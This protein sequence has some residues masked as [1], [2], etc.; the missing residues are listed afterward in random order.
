[1]WGMKSSVVTPFEDT[2]QPRSSRRKGSPIARES[3]PV[4]EINVTDSLGEKVET[5][6]PDNPPPPAAMVKK[7]KKDWSAEESVL[8]GYFEKKSSMWTPPLT[9]RM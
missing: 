9:I 3:S 6:K 7:K 2:P 5:I 8:N 4:P 1:M